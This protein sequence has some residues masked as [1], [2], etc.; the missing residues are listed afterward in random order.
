MEIIFA[1]S[2]SE[3]KSLKMKHIK[4]ANQKSAVSLFLQA[5]TTFY[6]LWG[7]FIQE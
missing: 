3:K 5:F 6:K 2:L 4:H 1:D 7:E